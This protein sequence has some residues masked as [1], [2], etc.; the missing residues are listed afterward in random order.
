MVFP[1]IL[2]QLIS[3]N[4]L[5]ALE[6]GN[7]LLSVYITVLSGLRIT[8]YNFFFKN[9]CLTSPFSH[10]MREQPE[11]IL[12]SLKPKLYCLSPMLAESHQ[13]NCIPLEMVRWGVSGE[14]WGLCFFLQCKDSKL[15]PF[16]PP[17]SSL[18]RDSTTSLPT[19]YDDN[20]S[21]SWKNL[22]LNYLKL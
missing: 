9:C 1:T 18:A 22:N 7:H 10:W 6:S 3:G 16:W 11:P 13:T 21:N 20:I 14:R 2:N 19:F 17:P 12:D 15:G 4:S 8:P 5:P